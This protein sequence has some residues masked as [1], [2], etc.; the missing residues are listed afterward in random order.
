MYPKA[1]GSLGRVVPALFIE[2]SSKGS[3][4][5]SDGA[6]PVD[7]RFSFVSCRGTGPAPVKPKPLGCLGRVDI[8]TL[9]RWGWSDGVDL[10][11]PIDR[12][13]ITHRK[14]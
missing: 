4:G 6:Q 1:S 3:I 2:V 10:S 7:R 5:L 11:A 13:L 9:F 14:L 12:P 8:S